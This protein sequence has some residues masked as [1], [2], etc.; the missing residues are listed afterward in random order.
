MA[1]RLIENLNS[2][3]MG[4]ANQLKSKCSRKKILA[5]VE[6][7]DD[8]LFWRN[9]LSAYE[10]EKRYFEV[11]LPSRTNLERGKKPAMMNVLNNSLGES[12]I[13]CVDADYDYLIQ[14]A[15]ITSRQILE[16][17]FI[18]H[19]YAYAIENYQCN[20]SDLH[21]VCVMA[22]LNDHELVDFESFFRLYSQI[23][24][25]LFVW[26]IFFYRQRDQRSFPM[27]E[28]CNAARI[29]L[30][31][32]QNPGKALEKL[33]GKIERKVDYLE[34]TYPEHVAEVEEVK[35]DLYQL[36]VYPENT[37][38]FIQGH[39]LF[40]NVTLKLLSPVCATLRKERE[41]EIK[42]LASHEVQLQNE[43]TS[44][45][46]SQCAVELMLKKNRAITNC[47]PFEKLKRDLDKYL[48]R[49]N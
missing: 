44:Y 6:S 21:E 19:T 37:Y 36:G 47:E 17:P 29:D 12:V 15:T 42:E 32:V 40:E 34:K 31:K 16:N 23:V 20:A 1:K 38:Y 5:Y 26:N 43:L 48:A 24:Y 35:K 28:F 4:A 33:Q 25:P 14:G 10:N 7:Y 18:F 49:L 41:N 8:I 22:T 11:M 27:L 30:V 3:Y 39:H 45:A 13:A 2:L 9:V 46:H